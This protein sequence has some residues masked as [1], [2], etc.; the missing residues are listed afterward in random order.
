[1][2]GSHRASGAKSRGVSV[3]FLTLGD[4]DFLADSLLHGL[5]KLLGPRVVDYPRQDILYNDVPRERLRG[6]HGRGFTLYGM[7]EDEPI[8]RIAALQRISSADF[9]LVVIADIWR[10]YGMFL[11]LLPFLNAVQ[12]AILD[13]ED[14]GGLYPYVPDFWR[15]P[16]AWVLPRAH[17]RSHYFKRELS[18]ATFRLPVGRLLGIPLRRGLVHPIS[19]SIPEEKIAAFVPRKIKRFPRHIV[20][21]DVADR[22]D[23]AQT[24]YVFA[25]EE[26]YI[27]DLRAS[28]F[29]IT[30][31]RSGWDCLRHYELAASGCALCFRAIRHKP[32]ACAP[33]GLNAAN[34]IAYDDANELEVKL[35]ALSAEDVYSLQQAALRWATENTTRRRAAEFLNRLGYVV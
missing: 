18:P 26:S 20:D 2:T 11:Q 12:V 13:G 21:P 28:S 22:V 5:R 17:A 30:T 31:K 1:M 24:S 15:R 9:N 16:R 35:A 8:D 29:A 3:L 27:C 25:D 19:F 32:A 4:A 14:Y 34:C 10:Q 33:T 6:M 7:L 23:G